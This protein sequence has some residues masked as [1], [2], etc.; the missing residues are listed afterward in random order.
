MTTVEPSPSSQTMRH[1]I[2]AVL[3]A[4]STAS[5]ETVEKDPT[6]AKLLSVGATIGGV[7]AGIAMKDEAGMV[8]ASAALV[9][10]PSVGHWYAGSSG[11]AGLAIRGAGFGVIALTIA[12]AADCSI[13][14]GEQKNC[15]SKN[16][17]LAIG[18][19]V[20]LAGVLYDFGTVGESARRANRRVVQIAPTVI[21][22]PQS[23]GTGLGLRARF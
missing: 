7:A 9:L 13:G 12:P 5:A 16:V 14:E 1:L 18:A 11:A 10:G 2:I 4:S 15:T 6:T 21:S 3:L 20:L 22:G 23:R 8:M 19:G 17:G